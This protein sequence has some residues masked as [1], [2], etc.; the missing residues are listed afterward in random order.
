M[1]LHKSSGLGALGQGV[2]VWG[3]WSKE[4]ESWSPGETPI[5]G[6]ARSQRQFGKTCLAAA[7]A[8]HLVSI[9]VEG[10]AAMVPVVV[11]EEPILASTMSCDGALVTAVLGCKE[12][13]K[14]GHAIGIIILGRASSTLCRPVQT[15]H[16]QCQG[17]SWYVT[18]FVS[19]SCSIL[20]MHVGHEEWEPSSCLQPL[21]GKQCSY[22]SGLCIPA[23]GT[24][25]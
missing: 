19:A 25:A 11:F 18:S 2:L 4:T 3:C 10:E 22:T 14:T 16:S 23:S 6:R 13:S 24:Q 21:H 12:L 20:G 5:W 1:E 7:L 8:Q 17:W 15:R 9:L